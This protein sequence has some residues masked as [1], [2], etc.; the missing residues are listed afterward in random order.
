M[1]DVSDIVRR[2]LDGL[3]ETERNMAELL[4]GYFTFRSNLPSQGEGVKTLAD[5]KTTEDIRYELSDM[6]EVPSKFIF[7]YMKKHGY[8]FI[9]AQDGSVK[10][11]IWMTAMS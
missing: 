5:H 4:D 6:M 1:A 3:D 10:W 2:W 11:A 7:S 8:G 9:T